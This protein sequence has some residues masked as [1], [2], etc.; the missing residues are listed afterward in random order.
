M[1]VGPTGPKDSGQRPSLSELANKKPTK[2]TT[3]Q[4]TPDSDL[5]K[6]A[7]AVSP[8]AAPS[9]AQLAGKGAVA[10]GLGVDPSKVAD[11]EAGLFEKAV[12]GFNKVFNFK[13]PGTNIRPA[14]VPFYPVDKLLE[15]EQLLTAGAA[16]QIENA[17]KRKPIDV[18]S[19]TDPFSDT[20]ILTEV[21]RSLTNAPRKTE[22]FKAAQEQRGYGQLESIENPALAFAMDVFLSPTTY[23]TGGGTGLG[24]SFLTQV[25]KGGVTKAAVRETG[26]AFTKAGARM[27]EKE[28]AEE[29]ARTA[30]KEATERA[31]KEAVST[32]VYRGE[33]I[34]EKTVAGQAAIA[35]AQRVFAQATKE[36]NKARAAVAAEEASAELLEQRALEYAKRYGARR[37]YGARSAADTASILADARQTASRTLADDDALKAGKAPVYGEITEPLDIARRAKVE[38]FANLVT[39][40]VI[41]NVATRGYSAIRGPLTDVLGTQA[42]FRLRGFGLSTPVFGEGLANAF[43]SGVTALRVGKTPGVVGGFVR[44]P[45]GKAVTRWTTQVGRKGLVGEKNVRD[46]RYELRSGELSGT[47]AAEAVQDLAVDRAYR[48]FQSNAKQQLSLTVSP[49]FALPKADMPFARTVSELVENPNVNLFDTM[50]G[51]V[52]VSADTAASASAKLRRTVTDEELDFARRVRASSEELY[53]QVNEAHREVQRLSGTPEAEIINLPRRSNWYPHALTDKAIDF[54]ETSKSKDVKSLLGYDRTAL[55]TL[56]TPRRIGA[57]TPLRNVNTGK[58]YTLTPT[59]VAGG[60]KELNK[61]FRREL[62]IKFD[63]FIE[64]VGEAFVRQIDTLSADLAFIETIKDQITKDGL[65]RRLETTTATGAAARPSMTA[66]NLE[67]S[68]AYT[69][70]PQKLGVINTLPEAKAELDDIVAAMNDLE[71]KVKAPGTLYSNELEDATTRISELARTL[72]TRDDVVTASMGAVATLEADALYDLLRSQARGI[73]EEIVVRPVSDWKKIVPVWEDGF[74]QLN[75]EVFPNVQARR[76]IAL[77]VQNMERFNDPKFVRLANRVAG[78]Y[79]RIFKSWVTAT[80]GFHVRNTTSNTFFMAAAGADFKNIEEAGDIYNEWLE[81]LNSEKSFLQG[82]IPESAEQAARAGGR[83]PGRTFMS[84]PG[85]PFGKGVVLGQPLD[86]ASIEEFVE[87][88][89]IRLGKTNPKFDVNAILRNPAKKKAI[90]NSLENVGVVGFGRTA[91]VFEELPGKLGRDTG[92]LGGESSGIL[93]IPGVGVDV[94]QVLGKPLAASRRAGQFIEGY[95]RFA[96]TY[97][98]VMKGLTAEQAATRTARY[99]IDYSDISRADA[100]LKQIIPFWMWISRSA[101]LM[102]E[103]LW[104]N[105]KAYILYRKTKEALRDEEDESPLMPAW[106]TSGGAFKAPFDIGG[107]TYLQPDLGFTSL[108]E[109]IES[110]TSPLGILS[111]LNPAIRAPIEA[112]ANYD[113]FRRTQIANKEFDPEADKKIR[114]NLVA[115]FTVLGPVMQKYGRVGAAISEVFNQDDLADTIRNITLTE[116]PDYL[117]QQG[118]TEPEYAQNINTLASFFGLQTRNLLPY[119]EQ[120]E[121]KRRIEE[122]DRLLKERTQEIAKGK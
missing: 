20:G 11:T 69:L 67:D 12:G 51:G 34:V 85:P 49:V 97:D 36:A 121:A 70:T 119:Q 65:F 41:G 61:I 26:E 63:F 88:Y 33:K 78:K 86:K 38:E 46:L 37:T 112:L 92:V 109:D 101:P 56:S 7:S 13:I 39:D 93:T 79:N 91:E 83:T 54:I 59:D 4:P 53:D 32:G 23:L 47:K 107:K 29:A 48:R 52:S 58:V 72:S 45:V 108:G 76:E 96:L 75:R 99:L 60:V 17:I 98:G 102:A 24:K 114:Q 122:L 1:A 106:M 21:G 2:T 105:P 118:I 22:L 90:V 115:Q 15:I 94:S 113:S 50:V 40:E 100:V 111:S 8:Q 62:G 89:L 6:R 55:G 42:G 82:A 74:V 73:K 68:I 104:T 3:T 64:D 57:G 87:R 80:P 19:F 84:T 117:R 116:T 110:I 14:Y 5:L 18:G 9:L 71:A 95:Q 77:M 27:L 28:T 30:L 44:T 81:F 25:A 31:T 10:R 120:N 103:T 43:G 66:P 16:K 35:D